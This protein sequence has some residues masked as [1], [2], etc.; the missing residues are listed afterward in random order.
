[1]ANAPSQPTNLITEV[2]EVKII[3]KF[4]YKFS[5]VEGFLYSQW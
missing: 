4:Y 2:L 1:V 5:C 3:L